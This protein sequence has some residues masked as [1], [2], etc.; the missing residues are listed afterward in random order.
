M[1]FQDIS[2]NVREVSVNKFEKIGGN[3]PDI[4]TTYPGKVPEDVISGTA[5][6][7]HLMGKPISLA[8]VGTLLVF[9]TAL[10]LFVRLRMTT[11][12]RAIEKKN[13][14][15]SPTGRRGDPN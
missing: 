9:P 11:T 13:D 5:E 12:T 4:S 1:M 3:S 14:G 2:E 8:G 7:P 6:V 10:L 15:H